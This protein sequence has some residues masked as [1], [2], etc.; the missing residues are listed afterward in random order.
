MERQTQTIGKM[1]TNHLIGKGETWPLYTAVAA[2]AI[3]TFTS[4]ALSYFSPLDGFCV[5]TERLA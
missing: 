5:E 3:N 4:P 1:I 2:D